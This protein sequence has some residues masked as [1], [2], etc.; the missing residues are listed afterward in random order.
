MVAYIYLAN[1]Q[2]TVRSEDEMSEIR[3]SFSTLFLLLCSQ[4]SIF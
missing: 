2:G 3:Q 4:P 1:K